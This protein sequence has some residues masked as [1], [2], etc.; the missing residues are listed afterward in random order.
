MP[1]I[2]IFTRRI[3]SN[4]LISIYNYNVKRNLFVLSLIFLIFFFL[5]YF[6]FYNRS[7]STNTIIV[8]GVKINIEIAD[9]PKKREVG[10]MYKTNLCETCGM[11][12]VFEKEGLYPFWMKNTLISLDIIFINKN[13]TIVDVVR[14][15]PVDPCYK[16][17]QVDCVIPVASTQNLH[18]FVL[19][20]NAGFAKMHSIKIGDKVIGL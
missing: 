9:T 4:L 3:I 18:K 6:Y 12:F 10:L 7:L 15:M 11:L 17:N 5:L 8:N 14:N 19:E 2:F 1:E 13:G 16:S 20:V